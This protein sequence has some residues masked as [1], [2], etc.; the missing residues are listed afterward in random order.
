MTDFGTDP[1][2]QPAEPTPDRSPAP[3][4]DPAPPAAPE[5]PAALPALVGQRLGGRVVPYWWLSGLVSTA[6][7]AGILFVVGL[8][9]WE[10]RKRQARDAARGSTFDSAHAG[11]GHHG[12]AGSVTTAGHGHPGARA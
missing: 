1:L 2:P 10:K 7:L 9:V 11:G 3:S 8:V 12:P 6:V 4:A 5:L